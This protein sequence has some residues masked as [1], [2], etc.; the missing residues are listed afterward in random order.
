REVN[1]STADCHDDFCT[2]RRDSI[3]EQLLA[4]D[5]RGYWSV[6]PD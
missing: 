5:A 4:R 1:I 3:G 2:I 6:K